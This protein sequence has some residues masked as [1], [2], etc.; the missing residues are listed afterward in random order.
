MI[1]DATDTNSVFTGTIGVLKA[2]IE[3]GN[4]GVTVGDSTPFSDSSG[5]LTLQNIDALDATTEATIEAAIDTLSNLTSIGTIGTGVWQGTTVA[6][7]YG[8]TGLNAVG[9]SGKVLV[10]NGS[11]NVYQDI[12]GGTFS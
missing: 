1:P 9:T 5:T 8:G 11:A 6:V 3:T 7:G 2:N 4:T 10:S 12:D